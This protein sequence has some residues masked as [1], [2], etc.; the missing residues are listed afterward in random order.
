LSFPDRELVAG[1]ALKD[2]DKSV[3]CAVKLTK[4]Q[5]AST[6]TSVCIASG[7]LKP[8]PDGVIAL[9]NLQVSPDARVGPQALQVRGTAVSKDLKETPLRDVQ[10]A[11]SVRA[12]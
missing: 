11:V 10:P 12:K 9:L 7:G 5:D 2:S 1:P 8:I 6:F 3:S 4:S